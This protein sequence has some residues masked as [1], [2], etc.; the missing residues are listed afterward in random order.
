MEMRIRIRIRIRKDIWSTIAGKEGWRVAPET[1]SCRL[2]GLPHPPRTVRIVIAPDSFKGSLRSPAVATAMAVGARRVYPNAEI[3][4]VPVGDGGEGTLDALLASGQSTSES[5]EVRDPLGRVRSARFGFMADGETVYVEMAE[6]SGLSC[7]GAD[8]RDALVATSYGTGEMLTAAFQSGRPR[9]VVGLG[10][11]ATNDGGAGL[12]TAMGA[13]LLKAD[14]SEVEPGGAGL[15][16]IDRIDLSAFRGTQNGVEIIVASD[17]TNPLCGPE[18][19][20]AIYGPQKGAT[21]NDVRLLDA[22]LARFADVA[23]ATL[24]RDFRDEQGAGAAGGLGF[25]LLAFFGAKIQRGVELVLEMVGL[26]DRLRGADLALTGEGRID[27]QSFAFGKTIAGVGAQCTEAGVPCIA[28]A[29]GITADVG[30][31][32][33][34]AILDVIPCPMSLEEAMAQAPGLIAKGVERGLR[35]YELGRHS[36]VRTPG[37]AA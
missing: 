4:E 30:R 8:E 19:A 5:I 18:G 33:V 16:E 24:G 31:P 1:L 11:S 25:S 36:A 13:R 21:T 27:G 35:L 10:G 17:V 37:A 12:L 3:V 14:G 28:F 29:G 9:V 6:A 23:S 22:S 2:S 34:D 7:L 15:G 26:P 32:G 20:S